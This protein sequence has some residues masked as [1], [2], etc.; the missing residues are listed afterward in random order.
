M[1]ERFLIVLALF[2]LIVVLIGLNAASYSR[3]E[4]VPDN[5]MNPNR[6]TYNSGATGTRAFYDL[7][8][9]TGRKVTRWQEPLS[10]LKSAGKN[11]PNTFVVVGSVRREFEDGDIK[12]LLE[13]VA[14]GGK[15]VIIDREPP[16]ELLKTTANWDI[17]A[18]PETKESRYGVDPS[19][20]K[21]MTAGVIAGK[22]AQPTVYTSNVNAV[23]PSRFASSF[24]FTR[25]TDA[26]SNA[27]PKD[28]ITYAPTPKPKSTESQNKIGSGKDNGTGSDSPKI[29][30]A[31]TPNPKRVNSNSNQIY[32]M[33][34]P[35]P[36]PF[37]TVESDSSDYDVS[38]TPAL[39]APVVHLANDKKVLLSDF[40]YGSGRIVYLT[41]PYIVTNSGIGLVDNA[42]LAL[43]IVASS[44]GLIAFDEYHQGYGANNNEL[45]SYFTGTPVVPF[46]LQIGVLIGLIF[47]SQSRRFARAL[48]SD[49]PNRLSKLEYV[50]AMAELQQR[51][52]AFDLAIENIYTD[53]RRRVSRSFGVD[54]RTTRRED[55][56][57]LIAE[58]I[59]SGN[60]GEIDELMR[61][62]E[63]ISHGE[64][65]NK[66]EVL[67]LA[68]QLRELEEKLGLQR[69]KRRKSVS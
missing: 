11:K 66:K 52:K 51:T 24:T 53:F 22:P 3:Q 57:R 23:Q 12:L 29:V 63:D 39:A 6:S 58:R 14:A 16:S 54:N 28:K 5:E 69:R 20:Q 36:P 7:L 33:P 45:L 55:L 43:N 47:Y 56:A 49:D 61:K 59:S 32:T 34:S 67:R 38:K 30:T 19:D 25:F 21:Q 37:S 1:K 31:A 68:G 44:G 65:T 60:S 26:D 41:D 62:C 4:K 2:V 18:V 50:A 27:K 42:Q 46:I 10:G 35:T 64:R 48:P 9:E 13:W 15:L 40:P 8:A 17:S